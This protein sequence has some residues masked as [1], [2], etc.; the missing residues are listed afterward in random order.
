MPMKPRRG[1]ATMRAPEEIVRQLL[2]ARPLERGDGDAERAG[3]LED[4]LDGAV[5]AGGIDALQHHQQRALAFGVEPVL[6]LVD[7]LA[8]LLALLFG[9]LAVGERLEVGRIAA[10]EMSALA[11]LDAKPCGEGF[12]HQAYRTISLNSG[13]LREIGRDEGASRHDLEAVGAGRLKRAADE[14]R[15]DALAPQGS[16]HLGVGEGDDAG[17]KPIVGDGG[18]IAGIHLEAV[19]GL[20]VA[21]GVGHVASRCSKRKYSDP[22]RIASAHERPGS[23]AGTQMKGRP[24]GLPFN[25]SARPSRSADDAGQVRRADTPAGTPSARRRP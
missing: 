3:L 21:D 8:V 6:Q 2:L 23:D 7:G 25:R 20:V 24:R 18:V 15:A 13:C 5:L 22:S 9:G 4:V 1:A 11:R 17:L 16:R 14:L 12:G 19:L 10:A